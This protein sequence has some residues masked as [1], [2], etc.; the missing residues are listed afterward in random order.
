MYNNAVDNKTFIKNWLKNH[1]YCVIATS[2][3]GK[4]WAA[5]VNYTA[6]DNLNIYISTSPASLK[7]LNATKNPTVALVIDNQTRAGT[8][9]IQGKTKP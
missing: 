4:P 3:K 9:Q 8:L 5:T 6:D 7:Y 1:T 2:Y